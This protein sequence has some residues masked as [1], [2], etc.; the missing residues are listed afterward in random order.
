MIRMYEDMP[1]PNSAPEPDLN[2]DPIELGSGGNPP[3]HPPGGGTHVPVP[4]GDVDEDLDMPHDP[5]ADG[6]LPPGGGPQGPGPGYG[7]SPDEPALPMEYHEES[8]PPGG[9]PDAPGAPPQYANPDHVLSPPMPWPAPPSQIVPVPIPP[10]PQFPVPH[11]LRPPSPRNVSSTRA[12]GQHPDDTSKAKSR[13]VVG[14]PVVLLPGQSAGKKDPPSTGDFRVVMNPLLRRLRRHRFRVCLSLRE[15][16]LFSK[17]HFRL[18]PRN[19][20]CLQMVRIR[21]R[22]R[23]LTI[24]GIPCL[25]WLLV[26]TKF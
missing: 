22:T 5:D 19:L 6:G 18:L 20:L 9:P 13:T 25:P 4:G 10:H 17:R 16:S 26:T 2:D 3:P 12:R 11:S 23:P 21:I 14:P 1:P 15:I 8:P 24:V 7:P